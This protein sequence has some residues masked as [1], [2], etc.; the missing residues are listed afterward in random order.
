[1]KLK[2]L[3]VAILSVLVSGCG[4]SGSSGP[5]DDTSNEQPDDD[6]TNNPDMNDPG[7]TDPGTTDPGTDNPPNNNNGNAGFSSVQGNVQLLGFI[8]IDDDSVSQTSDIGG[9]FLRFSSAINAATIQDGLA[10][11]IIDQ[12]DVSV[13]TFEGSDDLLDDLDFDIP[14]ETVSA[15][16]T[17]T[18]SSGSG[19]YGELQRALLFG[20]TTYN[21]QDELTY[22]AP[23]PLTI[24]IPGDVFPAFSNVSVQAPPP[25]SGFNIGA[26]DTVNAGT[27][28]SWDASDIQ[29][30][31][32]S[33]SFSQFDF[34]ALEFV[35]I[36]CLL[37]DDGAFSFSPSTV[38]E[39]NDSL[40]AGWNVT[41]AGISRETLVVQQQGSAVL[42][43]TR[44][45][46]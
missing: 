12:C 4:S 8:D 2:L 23:S 17:I 1:M 37:A 10:D 35:S 41:G 22:P 3:T 19:T 30:S 7:T 31:T 16:E 45:S 38:A 9:G 40:G 36:D 46:N 24:D 42:A 28:F 34:S 13:T 26:I 29:N 39:I 5:D 44:T 20:F 32:I 18:L 15:G 43:V 21:S 27:A 6:G 33:L 11:E 25:I 14:F